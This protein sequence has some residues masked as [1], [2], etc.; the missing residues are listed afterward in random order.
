L[1]FAPDPEGAG[2]CLSKVQKLE[3][4]PIMK[5]TALLGIVL[6]VLG[7]LAFGYQGVLWVTA[8]EEVARIGPVEVQ[9]EKQVPIPL[10]PIVGGVALLGG[11]TLLATGASRNP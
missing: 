2:E 8:R 9:R 1:P 10:A 11:L 6:V 4:K 5:P 3:E 7:I